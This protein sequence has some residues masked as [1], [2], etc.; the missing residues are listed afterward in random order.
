M[1]DINH[2]APPVISLVQRR[3]WDC[4]QVLISEY[5]RMIPD[6]DFARLMDVAK[7]KPEEYTERDIDDA[8]LIYAA[9]VEARI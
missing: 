6:D 5:S 7:L 8:T 2:P 9:Y 1:P 4:V 3:A